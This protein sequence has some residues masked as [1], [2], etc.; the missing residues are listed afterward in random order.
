MSYLFLHVLLL[1]HLELHN[2]QAFKHLH[3][4]LMHPD[5]QVHFKNP[6]PV[7]IDCSLA[8]CRTLISVSKS[9]EPRSK[10]LDVHGRNLF[11]END[12]DIQKTISS[13]KFVLLCFCVNI[14]HNAHQIPWISSTPINT[15]YRQCD[16]VTHCNW[17]KNL[18]ASC[19]HFISLS[20]KVFM[21][22]M[23]LPLVLIS[24]LCCIHCIN[25]SFLCHS[26]TQ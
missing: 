10:V 11:L 9:T 14:G 4:F 3:V 22:K 16:I 12:L 21:T 25:H 19:H 7:P 1:W 20:F 23:A 5:L 18:I 17:L 26:E 8:A 6:C 13:S 15:W 2:I 24:I